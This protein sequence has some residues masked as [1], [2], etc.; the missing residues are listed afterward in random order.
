MMIS[1]HHSARFDLSVQLSSSISDRRDLAILTDFFYLLFNIIA[2]VTC[3]L[4]ALECDR[5]AK[6]PPA[7]EFL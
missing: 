6:Q 3:S 4:L 2:H 5:K 1:R 7:I